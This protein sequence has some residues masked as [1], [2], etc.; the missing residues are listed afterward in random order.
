MVVK[1]RRLVQR[2]EYTVPQHVCQ[3]GCYWIAEP[4]D[5]EM[6]ARVVLLTRDIAI[7]WLKRNDKNRRFSR[8]NAGALVDE[9][10][11]GYWLENGESIVF[12]VNGVLVDGQHRL[13]AVLNTGYE[14]SVPVITGVQAEVRPTVDTGMKRTGGNNL[15]MVGEI[16]SG[17][18]AATILLW[19]GY[20]SRQVAGMTHPYR[21]TS[22]SAIMKYLEEW[23]ELRLAVKAARSLT[24]QK[25]G[26][27]I[28]PVSEVAMIWNA[29]VQSGASQ[30]RAS[31]FLG[32]VLS[33]F[34]LYPGNP[35]LALRRRLIEHMRPGHRMHKRERLALILRAWQLWSTG[36]MRQVL[37]WEPDQ[38]F[39][40]L[41]AAR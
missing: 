10:G 30:D 37:R 35:I 20:E 31:E 21:R 41:E 25:Q 33:G 39:P 22:I 24:P 15:A 6:T 28:V 32:S 8:E 19:K 1:D 40:F 23:P 16:N 7:A 34:N 3:E 17:T 36:Q 4:I 29:I 11:S 26:R 9:M 18:L 14:Y 2:C 13:Q 12:D 5:A 27:A 38:E